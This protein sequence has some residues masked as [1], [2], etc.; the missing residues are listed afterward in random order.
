MNILKKGYLAN[1]KNYRGIT[2]PG[3]IL[4]RSILQRLIAA[5]E[6]VLRC[7]HADLESSQ[8]S[9]WPLNG[10]HPYILHS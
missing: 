4:S 1:Y 3:K 8:S 9:H 6:E 7:M 10:T 2:V 5:L